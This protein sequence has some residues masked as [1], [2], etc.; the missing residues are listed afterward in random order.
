MQIV[1]RRAG[2]RDD[3]PPANSERDDDCVSTVRARLTM[4]LDGTKGIG[5]V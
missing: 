2:G 5:T 3:G 1:K 4:L